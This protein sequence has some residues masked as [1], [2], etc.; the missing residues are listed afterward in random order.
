MDLGNLHLAFSEWV[1]PGPAG[2]LDKGVTGGVD[3][4]NTELRSLGFSGGLTDNLVDEDASLVKTRE[5]QNAWDRYSLLA[6]TLA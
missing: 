6:R 4:T 3:L 1:L 5:K 2:L